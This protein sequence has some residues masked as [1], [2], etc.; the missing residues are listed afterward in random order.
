MLID[1][2]KAVRMVLIVHPELRKETSSPNHS[3]KRQSGNRC[4]ILLKHSLPSIIE[5]G[6]QR[7]PSMKR[8]TLERLHIESQFQCLNIESMTIRVVMTRHKR[9]WICGRTT[10]GRLEIHSG[11]EDIP[12]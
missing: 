7:V 2:R 3:T 4:K 10:K 9:T 6:L 1:H 12:K 8:K 5:I 11:E